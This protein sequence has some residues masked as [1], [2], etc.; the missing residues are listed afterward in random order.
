MRTNELARRA[1]SQWLEEGG[2]G[3]AKAVARATDVS[4][5]AVSK[6]V[7]G[8]VQIPPGRW[9]DIERACG[10]PPLEL[11]RITGELDKLA[12][13]DDPLALWQRL[14]PSPAKRGDT[15]GLGAVDRTEAPSPPPSALEPE[16][17]ALVELLQ[18]MQAS[19]VEIIRSQHA[20]ESALESIQG[21]LDE[22][23]RWQRDVLEHQQRIVVELQQ[24]RARLRPGR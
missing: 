14:H 17:A 16:L 11:A 3:T 5:Q 21:V 23:D 13:V 8:E 24:M 10:K 9:L 19:Q 7:R 15:E 2:R 12:G 20:I 4:P 22:G 18:A 6:W 1:L